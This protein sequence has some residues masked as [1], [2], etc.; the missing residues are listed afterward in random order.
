MGK[1]EYNHC[2]FSTVKIYDY[3]ETLLKHTY[4]HNP[5]MIFFLDKQLVWPRDTM[6]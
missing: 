4:T 5:M 6:W 1:P 3:V 2:F